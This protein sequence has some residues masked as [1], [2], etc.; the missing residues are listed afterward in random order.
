MFRGWAAQW[1]G[2]A[3]TAGVKTPV[4]EG[5]AKTVWQAHADVKGKGRPAGATK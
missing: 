5:E 4:F 3:T 2:T 1:S